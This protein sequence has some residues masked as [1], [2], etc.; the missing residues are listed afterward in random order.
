MKQAHHIVPDYRCKELGITTSYKVNI[1]GRKVEFYFKENYLPDIAQIEH[2]LIH[3]GYYCDDLEPLFKYVTP[4]QWVIDLIPIG[5]ARDYGAAVLTARGGIDGIVPLRGEEHP[6]WGKSPSLE[7][8]K[9]MSDNN[10][11][12]GKK[13]P[14]HAKFMREAYANGDLQHPMKGKHISDETK[15]K[16][17]IANI[18]D[19]NNMFG[20]NHTPEA[21]KKM[22]EAR[23]NRPPVSMETRKKMSE[24]HKGKD[25]W[26]KGKK[27]PQIG[28]KGSV[29]WNKGKTGVCS[30]ET[31]KKMSESKKGS[32]PWNKGTGMTKE[33]IIRKQRERR[34]KNKAE[35][36]YTEGYSQAGRR[37]KKKAE[38]QGEGTLKAFL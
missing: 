15:K 5:D 11:W 10:A 35:T 13:R 7:S 22:T 23:N 20:K 32:V 28:R 2:A 21:I 26:N 37:K 4:P 33:E 3:W 6:N 18:G 34:A 38:A 31:R 12:R 24:A 36:G 17:S 16:I 19:R 9:K 30:E 8:R 25:T 29:P 14:E 27:C 1:N